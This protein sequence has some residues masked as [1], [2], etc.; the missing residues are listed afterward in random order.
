MKKQ[1][2]IL[3]LLSLATI[4]NASSQKLWN[5][6]DCM[7]YAVKNSNKLKSHELTKDD[8]KKDLS[9]S[10]LAFL[11]TIS[12]STSLNNNYGRSI[13]PETNSYVSTSNLSNN[14]G[15][16]ADVD[17]F[18]GL[19][20]VNNLKIAKVAKQRAELEGQ[21][22]ETSVATNTMNAYYQ[23][24]FAYGA[25]QIAREELEE[26]RQLY[27]KKKA[28]HEV[29]LANISDLAQLESRV[30]QSEYNITNLK[31]MYRKK[32][33]TL[34]NEMYF[35]LD[36]ELVVDT[37]LN[38]TGEL[39]HG[40]ENMKEIFEMTKNELPEF[41]MW[42]VDVRIK[43]L[44]L[45]KARAQ[46]YPTFK[47]SGGVSTGYSKFFGK[48]SAS[49]TI[50]FSQQFEDRMGENIGVSL[51]IP[52]FGGL[53]RRKN[54]QRK[55]NDY[56]RAQITRTEQSREIESLVYQAV[57]DLESYQEQSNKSISNV[58]ANELSY[59]TTVAK[60]KEGLS[61]VVDLQTVQTNLSRAKIDQLRAY[62]NYKMQDR[63]VGY[64]KGE[65]LIK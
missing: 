63:I 1:I 9:E 24:V 19:Q 3:I 37:L 31:G 34:K 40:Q 36:V 62:L 47:A 30:S 64:Y 58:K 26:S 13:D 65:S 61:T 33:V 46:M 60:Y 22:I 42:D 43:E 48:D 21:Q 23:A 56:E 8:T 4:D 49:K 2:L 45:S 57:I 11:P 16:Y 35:P 38:P 18:N 29:G 54:M 20:N 39:I 59:K 5:L 32:V 7:R 15:A 12:A 50:G 10:Q 52:I 6:D 25:Y 53:T 55:R 27:E 51:S 44:E 17:I 14:Y 41:K 28:E